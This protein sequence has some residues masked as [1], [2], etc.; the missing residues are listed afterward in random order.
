MKGVTMLKQ[1]GPMTEIS[2]YRDREPVGMKRRARR[3][4]WRAHR[5]ELSLVIADQ[6]TDATDFALANVFTSHAE[7]DAVQ[8]AEWDEAV[9]VEARLSRNR[10]RRAALQ[11][12]MYELQ[13]EAERLHDRL[14]EMEGDSYWRRMSA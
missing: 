7:D 3:I 14:W 8:V 5:R 13:D 4:F 10:E 2:Y 12:E 6:L 11:D 1:T 9:Q